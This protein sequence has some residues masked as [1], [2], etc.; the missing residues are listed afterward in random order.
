M[1]LGKVF[2]VIRPDFNRFNTKVYCSCGKIINECP[3]W[4]FAT[5][6]LKKNQN[7]NFGERYQLVFETFCEIFGKDSILI[8]SSK[9]LDI[10]QVLL[11]IDSVD[12]KEIYLIRDVRAWTISRLNNRIESPEYFKKAGNY[13]KIGTCACNNLTGHY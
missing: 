9:L 4:G 5:D 13:Y 7:L 11:K 10:L 6:R 12:F 1:G 8:D 2:Q 3:F